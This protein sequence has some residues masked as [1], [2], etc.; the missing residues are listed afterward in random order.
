[1]GAFRK[2]YK[3]GRGGGGVGHTGELPIEVELNPSTHNVSYNKDI[4]H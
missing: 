4:F 1:M 2:K 3:K